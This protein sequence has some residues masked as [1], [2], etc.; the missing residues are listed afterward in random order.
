M[1]IKTRFTLGVAAVL[2]HYAAWRFGVFLIKHDHDVEGFGA[3]LFFMTFDIRWYVV[4]AVC[5]YSFVRRFATQKREWDVYGPILS[6]VSAALMYL[7]IQKY[8]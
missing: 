5:I 1:S 2:L 4:A 8:V 7:E 6:L 3:H